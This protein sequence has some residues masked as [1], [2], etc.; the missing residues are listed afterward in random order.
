MEKNEANIKIGFNAA[1]STAVALP[2]RC[3]SYE[4]YSNDDSIYVDEDEDATVG[5]YR[6]PKDTISERI[7]PCTTISVLGVSGAGL[8]EVKA[9]PMENWAITDQAVMDVRAPVK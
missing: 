4:I 5:S 9:V 2:G 8:A 7:V 6:V 3:F 1:T